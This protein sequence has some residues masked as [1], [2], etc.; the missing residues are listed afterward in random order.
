[1]NNSIPYLIASTEI[2][3]LNMIMVNV[4]SLEKID[5]ETRKS[6]VYD[7]YYRYCAARNFYQH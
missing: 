2:E 1:M 6:K 5:S 3:E 7:N 4:V